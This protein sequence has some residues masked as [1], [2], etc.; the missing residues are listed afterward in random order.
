MSSRKLAHIVRQGSGLTVDSNS[1]PALESDRPVVE[2]TESARVLGT[3]LSLCYPIGTPKLDYDDV[4]EVLEAANKYEVPRA[5]E[6]ATKKLTEYIRGDPLRAYFVAFAHGWMDEAKEAAKHAVFLPKDHYV[7]EME[8]ASAE[9]YW[10]LLDYRR[11]TAAAITN[12]LALNDTMDP[13]NAYNTKT[14]SKAFDEA[15][16]FNTYDRFDVGELLKQTTKAGLGY[17]AIIASIAQVVALQCQKPMCSYA[18]PTAMHMQSDARAVVI[19]IMELQGRL[20]EEFSKVHLCLDH[21]AA[22]HIDDE[23]LQVSW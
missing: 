18:G 6:V 9:A 12:A 1:R 16:G 3:L 8:R 13:S 20:D 22:P 19:R 23:F 21:S 5:I 7:P 2:F 11:R 17:E 15:N 14:L 4:A 10:R